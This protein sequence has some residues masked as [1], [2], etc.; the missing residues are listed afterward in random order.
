[1]PPRK[2]GHSPIKSNP[3]HKQGIID[4]HRPIYNEQNKNLHN[5]H[6]LNTNLSPQTIQNHNR[7]AEWRNRY[8]NSTSSYPDSDYMSSLGSTH[9]YS[10]TLMNRFPE[11]GL[12]WGVH[13]TNLSK[14]SALGY[15]NHGYGGGYHNYT[16]STKDD[17]ETTTTSG[18]YTIN[19]E[20]LDE[21]LA[22]VTRNVSHVV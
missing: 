12:T 5:K 17:D 20:D 14:M 15:V 13:N 22:N 10:Q 2:Y 4:H 6:V 1:M 11:N 3:V 7:T 19:H 16:S 21:E 18:S 9:N 8:L